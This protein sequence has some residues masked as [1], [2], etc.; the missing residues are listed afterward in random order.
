VNKPNIFLIEEDNDARRLFRERLK[1]DGY[2]VSLA[3]DEDDAI[4]RIGSG[5]KADLILI[6]LLE[7]SPDEILRFGRN[8]RRA[9]KLNA[10][11]VVIAGKYGADL[12]GTNAQISENEY[13][14]YLEDGEQLF[15]LLSSLTGRS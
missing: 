5:L 14:A 6:N 10:P 2:R 13:I 3:I 1:A 11:L 9:G 15:D 7:K 12:E 8:I 4:E